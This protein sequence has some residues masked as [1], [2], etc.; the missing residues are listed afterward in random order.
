M[1]H[2]KQKSAVE[3][4][5]MIKIESGGF[6]VKAKYSKGIQNN[7]YS[8][9]NV[10]LN[11]L[12]RDIFDLSN[13][14]ILDSP[15][16]TVRN[17]NVLRVSFK[18][19]L[20]NP[21]ITDTSTLQMK[22]RDVSRHQ[23]GGLGD[24][25]AKDSDIINLA[26]S[27]W[28]EN[29]PVNFRILQ[30]KGGKR[31]ELSDPVYGSIGSVPSEIVA[32]LVQLL[33]DKDQIDEGKYNKF[34]KTKNKHGNNYSKKNNK[35][36]D[37]QDY[38]ALEIPARRDYEFVLSN[39]IAG[40]T[41]GASTIGLR[42]NL[43]YTGNDPQRKA[44]TQRIFD[45]LLNSHDK[46][47]N[48]NVMVYQPKA[49]PEEVLERIFDIE[50]RE[51]GI[52]AV[53]EIKHA[54]SN[55]SDEINDPNNKNILILGHNKPDGD[56]L[57]C[58]IG[59]QT[60]IKGAYPD[61][62]ID[63]AVDDK[64]P[65]LFRN[66]MPGIENVKRPYNPDRIEMVKNGIKALKAQK[67]TPVTISQIKILEKELSELN[68]PE[69]LFDSNP[70]EGKERKKYDLVILM[71]IPTPK[72][73][74]NAFKE[75]VERANKVI[76]IDHHPMRLNE[77]REDQA[78]T[79]VN[80]DKIKKD[81]LAL[82]CES[83]PAATQLVTIITN[84]AGILNKTMKESF[85]EAKKFV[86]SVITGISTD[87]GCFTRTA[88]LLPEHMK[89]PVKM[90]PNFLPE[91]MSKWMIEELEEKSEGEIDKKWLRDNITF[92]IPD[93][94]LST[95]GKDGKLSPRDKMLTYAL[96]KK[97]IDRDLGLGIISAN[98]DQMYEIWEDSM[99]QDEDFT[100]LDVQNGFKYSEVMGALQSDPETVTKRSPKD[101]EKP[102][103]RERA[104]EI[105]YSPYNDDK[106]AVLIIQDR[107]KDHITENSDISKQNGLRFSFRSQD[108]STHARI[109]ALL[110]GGGG[111]GGA[112]GGRLD[113]P[114]VELDSK[115][116]VKIN[117]EIVNDPSLIYN[118]LKHNHEILFNSK[119]SKN[120]KKE[121]IDT[122]ELEMAEE[123]SGR[124][125]SE[126]INDI[127]KEIRAEDPRDN[128]LNCFKNQR[129]EENYEKQGS[130]DKSKFTA[131]DGYK[132]HYRK[133]KNKKNNYFGKW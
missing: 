46:K 125:P 74:T 38:E 28:K 32:P 24:L 133:N 89:L 115:I 62:N 8:Y 23:R 33:E 34:T 83:V 95:F 105:Y 92:D 90:R 126:L 103:L 16:K 109:L 13:K 26:E 128:T 98:Y 112:S 73:F 53:N 97:E 116:S 69:K 96:A 85:S 60:A 104:E 37:N 43:K 77:W 86:A 81:H 49:S 1:T 42:V 61:K 39:I 36:K 111:H 99:L 22:V 124:T 130:K 14:A 102:T 108:G 66:K 110:F 11:G 76:Y 119:F 94:R 75:Y 12:S 19:E 100:L 5:S 68:N 17:G 123:G 72:R 40:T 80:M 54:I 84:Q 50:R 44:S 58:I 64:I 47:I 31:I 15:I 91:G 122:I 48:D 93:N 101:P 2:L 114:N 3:E 107:K 79:G 65:G 131:P 82:V 21:I 18:G 120:E 56:T 117:G 129:F 121:L 29:Q 45:E 118:S 27:D 55:I 25:R 70:L 132:T 20:Q 87:T 41:K 88:N 59:M 106:I 113:L 67:Q 35:R 10:N 4:E 63:C 7:S 6:G 71:D 78:E 57:G 30:T 52:E 127:V 51:N 9:Y